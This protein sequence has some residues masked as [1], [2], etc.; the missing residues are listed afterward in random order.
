M[1][2]FRYLG[3]AAD[4]FQRRSR[5][6]E[7]LRVPFAELVR[8]LEPEIQIVYRL[9]IADALADVKNASRVDELLEVTM[10]EEMIE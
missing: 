7:K 10:R 4:G 9:D 3:L 8:Y 6:G 5:E 1:G 2:G